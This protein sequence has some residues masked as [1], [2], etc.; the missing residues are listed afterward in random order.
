[1]STW[2][3]FDQFLHCLSS[4]GLEA[5]PHWRALSAALQLAGYRKIWSQDLAI[6]Q[7]TGNHRTRWLSAW[8]RKDVGFQPSQERL[9]CA[10]NRRLPWNDSKHLFALPQ[11]LSDGL[12]LTPDQMV[13]YGNRDLLPPAKKVRVAEGADGHQ[14]LVQRVAHSGEYLPTLCA[15]YTGQHLL[16][17]EHIES[18][19]IF[20]TLTR[21]DDEFCFIDPPLLSQLTPRLP[22]ISL[23]TQSCK[24]MGKG[25]ALWP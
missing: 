18:K 5:H 17:R 4:D 25:F 6:H 19:G 13:I 11:T 7:L 16:Q 8:C 24:S 2:Y 15:S 14:V 3:G 1:M 10:A 9:L 12:K 20:A 23:A 21:R 22:S